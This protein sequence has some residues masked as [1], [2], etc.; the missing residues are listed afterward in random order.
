MFKGIK[1]TSEARAYASEQTKR[2]YWTALFD[3]DLELI[4]ETTPEGERA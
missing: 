1:G 4:E 3:G 2:G